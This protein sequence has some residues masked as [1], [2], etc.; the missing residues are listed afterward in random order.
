MI[1]QKKK[2]FPG[3][4]YFT[5]AILKIPATTK[6][7]SAVLLRMGLLNSYVWSNSGIR[8]IKTCNILRLC[9]LGWVFLQLNSYVWSN[10]GIRHIKTCN[11]FRLCCLGWVFLQLNSYVWSNS[12][13]RHIKTSPLLQSRLFLKVPMH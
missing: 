5:V 1:Y 9:C 8:H 10:S 4:T 12:G 6:H 7:F 3:E 2:L 13:I 11:I